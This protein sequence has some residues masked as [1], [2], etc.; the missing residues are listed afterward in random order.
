MGCKKSEVDP[1]KPCPFYE[2]DRSDGRPCMYRKKFVHDGYCRAEAE[3][4]QG[5]T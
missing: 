3:A 5:A 1:N 4:T 2:P